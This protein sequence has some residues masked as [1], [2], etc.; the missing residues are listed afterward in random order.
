MDVQLYAKVNRLIKDLREGRN[1]GGRDP[2]PDTA[3]S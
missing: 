1:G 2:G 3:A